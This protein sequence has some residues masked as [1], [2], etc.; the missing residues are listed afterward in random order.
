MASATSWTALTCLR[1]EWKGRI[2]ERE[3]RKQLGEEERECSMVKIK[4]ILYSRRSESKYSTDISFRFCN[5]QGQ[6]S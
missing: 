6:L 2:K 1:K 5:S 3:E 4:E